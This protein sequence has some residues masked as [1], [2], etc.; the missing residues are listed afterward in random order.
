VEAVAALG[1][2][3][4]LSATSVRRHFWNGEISFKELEREVGQINYE[5][6]GSSARMD[7]TSTN[8]LP[9]P[10]TRSEA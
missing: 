6:S 10:G 5:A 3:C 8:P 4:G 1:L 7:H 9:S 2:C